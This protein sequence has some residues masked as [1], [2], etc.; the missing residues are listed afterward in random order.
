LVCEI[1]ANTGAGHPTTGAGSCKDYCAALGRKC[2]HA[3]DNDGL[4]GVYD[5]SDE[6]LKE[7]GQDTSENGMFTSHGPMDIT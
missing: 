6:R 1:S 3:Q 2:F 4:C 7:L 5:V